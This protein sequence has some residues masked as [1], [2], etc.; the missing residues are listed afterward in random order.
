MDQHTRP[1]SEAKRAENHKLAHDL[2]NALS[3]I[4]LYAQIL[5]ASLTKLALENEAQ[6]AR[7][8]SDS[9]KDMDALIVEKFGGGI[10]AE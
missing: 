1:D 4:L 6:T 3:P 10:E 9:V 2:R 8:I 5:E 7:L